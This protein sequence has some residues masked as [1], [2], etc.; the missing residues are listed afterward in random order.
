MLVRK[1]SLGYA[2]DCCILVCL[3]ACIRAYMHTCRR[4]CLYVHTCSH[5]EYVLACKHAYRCADMHTCTYAYPHTRMDACLHTCMQHADVPRCMPM[6][7]VMHARA[8]HSCTPRGEPERM[9]DFA[10]TNDCNQQKQITQRTWQW[11]PVVLHNAQPALTEHPGKRRSIQ[12]V[13]GGRI[14]SLHTRHI[15]RCFSGSLPMDI[16]SAA[17][18]E[19]EERERG[20]SLGG[21]SGLSVPLHTTAASCLRGVHSPASADRPHIS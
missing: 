12:E 8:L 14:C 5:K 13:G 2:C 7:S 6:H 20:C 16:R 21:D 1:R 9:P 15:R 18:G 19:R 17:V 11:T 3:C 4:A 10:F